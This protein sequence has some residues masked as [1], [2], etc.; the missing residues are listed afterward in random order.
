LKIIDVLGQQVYLE[1]FTSDNGACI[2]E[3]NLKGYSKGIYYLLLKMGTYELNKK[4]IL[5]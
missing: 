3:I 2:K 5:E 1:T 4:I